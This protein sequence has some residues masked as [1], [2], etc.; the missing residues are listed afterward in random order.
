MNKTALAEMV[1][2]VCRLAW[3][4][5]LLAATDGNISAR[6]DDNRLLITPSGR[7]KAFV[8][9]GDLM[10]VDLE[11]RVLAGTGRPSSEARLHYLVYRLI[12]EARAVVHAHPPVATA[13][14]LAGRDL[15]CQGLP[16][17]V[18]GLG[19]IPTAPYATPTTPDLPAAV[20]PYLR[21]G[22]KALLLAHHGSLTWGAN[23]EAAW[24]L[25]EKVEHA[26]QVL[27]A[28]QALGGGRDLP[29]AELARLAG[30]GEEYGLRC[31]PP[32]DARPLAERV[33]VENLPLTDEFRYT[34]RYQD[35]RGEAHLIL[36]GQAVRKVALMTLKPGTGFRGGHFHRI[37]TEGM[38]V[39]S[40][41][42]RYDLTCIRTGET[43]Q[44]A[45]GPGDLLWMPVGVAHRL[46]ALE[47]ATLVELCD[48][49]YDPADDLK[50]EFPA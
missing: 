47:E 23:L 43:A 24:A 36:N 18:L 3:Q 42:I 22:H 9:P 19:S 41:R 39:V 50:F 16:E 20:E 5:G 1:V 13:F 45:M 33:R 48:T 6:L 11:G 32:V 46:A 2:R 7:S 38:Y 4:K 14:S 27:L 21:S 30:L 10:E 26:S 37:K 29:P 40:G 8:E 35:D 44:L 12:P 34:K 31:R 17:V 25:T 49:P 15:G 28:A